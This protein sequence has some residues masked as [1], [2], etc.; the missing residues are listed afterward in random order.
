MDRHN[1]M[2]PSEANP[3]TTVHKL[4]SSLNEYVDWAVSILE[5]VFRYSGYMAWKPDFV[6]F[7]TSM[8]NVIID[9]K[10]K[11]TAPPIGRALLR[12]EIDL[13]KA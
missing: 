3:S 10:G 2:K 5:F 4:V 13:T 6:Q 7:D 9:K 11:F 8:G 1:G 12:G